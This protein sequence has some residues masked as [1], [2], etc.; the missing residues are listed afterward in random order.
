VGPYRSRVISIFI[1]DGVVTPSFCIDIADQSTTDA[2]PYD[3]VDLWTAPDETVGAMGAAKA[4]DLTKL[5]S[6]YW[7]DTMTATQAAGLQLAI[8]N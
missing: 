7:T 6:A 5:L 1:H 8:W 4:A 3:V 2:V